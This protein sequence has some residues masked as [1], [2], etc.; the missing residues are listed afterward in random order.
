MDTIISSGGK[1]KNL[2]VSL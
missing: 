2:L 1:A